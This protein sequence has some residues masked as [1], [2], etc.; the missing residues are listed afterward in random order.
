MTLAFRRLLAD[1]RHAAGLT[2]VDLAKKLG[3]P[4]SVIS[5]VEQGERRLDVVEFL[6]VARALRVDPGRWLADVDRTLTCRP[7]V[8]PRPRHRPAEHRQKAYR[9]R[10]AVTAT[11]AQAASP[12]G[13]RATLRA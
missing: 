10:V 13:S 2:Q 7:S 3:R 11:N 12:A 9:Y 4:Q 5:K 6:E 8:R 1:A